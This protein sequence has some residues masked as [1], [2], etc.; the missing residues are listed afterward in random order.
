MAS[1]LTVKW[2]LA[3]EV[4]TRM[5]SLEATIAE[6]VQEALNVSRLLQYD[7][8]TDLP[9]STLL[10][11]R[12]NQAIVLSR[13]HNIQLAVIFIGLDRFQR[14]NSAL[15]HPTGDEMLKRVARC[16]VDTVRESDSVFR[17]GSDEFVLLL[18][19]IRHPE[20]TKGIAE[21]LLA[22]IRV[23]HYIAG[24]NLAV[25]GSLGISIFPDDGE[26]PVILTKKAETAMRTIKMNGP[27][28]FCFFADNLNQRARER[29]SI[30]SGIRLAL[31][32]E[33]FVLHYQPK[34]NLKTGKVVGAEALIR[35]YKPESGWIYPSDFIP[36]AEDCG[37]IVPLSKWVLRE[38]CRQACAWQ[39]A[40]LAAI[41]MSVN[42]SATEFRQ[43]GF[44]ESIR[45]V[46]DDTGMNPERLELEI[47]EGVLMQNADS[48]IQ[49][50]RAI[51]DMGVRLAIDDFGTGYSSLSYLRRFPIDVLKIDQSFIRALGTDSNDAALVSAIISLGKSLNLNII[52]EGIETRAQLDFLRAHHCEEGQGYFF[53]R[54]VNALA[55]ADILNAGRLETVQTD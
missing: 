33:E 29:Q 28:D 50:L 6:R 34:L 49:I 19:D 7:V 5:L 23:P 38:A 16:L 46:L 18:A 14:I 32:R 27:D 42:I 55:F 11:D 10:S 4:A 17:Y 41:H 35:W 2:Q 20:Q 40:G 3:R 25:T 48:T 43:K 24:H 9:N 52:A 45:A 39:A 47:T 53:S 51:K 12:L 22:A 26:D 13:R 37:L 31:E 54:A 15:G 44:L 30:E 8:L 21:K 36:V 1:A